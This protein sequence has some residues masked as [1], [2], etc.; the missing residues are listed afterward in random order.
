MGQENAANS[1]P[2]AT[3]IR[4]FDSLVADGIKEFR[5]KN[6]ER[7]ENLFET[8]ITVAEK[9]SDAQECKLIALQ[10]LTV[11]YQA[12]NKAEKVSECEKKKQE[13]VKE[14]NAK[15]SAVIK[16][17]KLALLELHTSGKVTKRASLGGAGTPDLVVSSNNEGVDALKRGDSGTAIKRFFYALELKPDYNLARENIA[18]A[19]NNLG[20]ELQDD[21]RVAV[22]CFHR[23]NYF[24]PG[25][26]DVMANLRVCVENLERKPD[27][28]ND[29]LA[30]AK[31]CLD[32]KEYVGAIVEYRAA[33]KLRPETSLDADIRNVP[34]PFPYLPVFDG[35][36]IIT[37][38]VAGPRD[39]RLSN[40][41][42]MEIYM[43]DL[44][45]AITSKWK[46]PANM[47]GHKAVINFSIS[48][49]GEVSEVSVG[50]TSNDQRID[51]L[52]LAAIKGLG[53]QSAL[54]DCGPYQF[55]NFQFVFTE[56]LSYGSNNLSILGLDYTPYMTGVQNQ[57][58]KVW[59]STQ[60]RRWTRSL[61]CTAL[62]KIDRSGAISGAR[63]S[64]S[65]GVPDYDQDAL[66]SLKNVRL[67]KPP[68]GSPAS[69]DIEFTFDY[70]VG[71]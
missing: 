26:K 21:P 13:L 7:A 41:K 65:S 25:N 55:L 4:S 66:G 9:R 33:Q 50:E 31:Q 42:A 27:N 62:F 15:T 40:E 69:I 24:N 46:A 39:I 29:R 34:A 17:D 11:L 44:Q 19:Y 6:Y 71:R 37:T 18:I 38:G 59:Y 63:I 67:G 45:K 2:S 8:A 43:V 30:L 16:A 61:H 49:S 28:Y 1:G 3:A 36:P 68:T 10:N 20:I 60:S 5:A 51:G 53:K 48:R 32:R 57:L 22:Q 54:P 23:A 12:Q 47:R 70:N 35:K 56:P 64:R 58:R 52:A 14:S